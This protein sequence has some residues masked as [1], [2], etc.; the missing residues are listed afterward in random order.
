MLKAL[1]FFSVEMPVPVFSVLIV[2]FM[3]L[4]RFDF[5]VPKLYGIRGPDLIFFLVFNVVIIPFQIVVNI[6]VHNVLELVY[7]WRLWEYVQFC[8]ARFKGRSRRWVGLDPYI[9]QALPAELRTLDQMCMSEQYYFLGAFHCGG[10][11]G[12]PGSFLFSKAAVAV[13]RRTLSSPL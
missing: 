2:A 3:F 4:F 6:L 11:D 12:G 5:D 9:N 7:N 1:F 10:I 13:P 8:R